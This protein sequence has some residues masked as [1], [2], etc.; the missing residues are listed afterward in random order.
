ML[1]E[2][3]SILHIKKNA[4]GKISELVWL[5]T[6]EAIS[7]TQTFASSISSDQN[8]DDEQFAPGDLF[9]T[10]VPDD[11]IEGTL[12]ALITEFNSMTNNTV[13]QISRS[14]FQIHYSEKSPGSLSEYCRAFDFEWATVGAGADVKGNVIVMALVPNGPT[15]Q[16]SRNDLHVRITDASTQLASATASSLT[17]VV[18]GNH[19]AVMAK[20]VTL[21]FV[22][23]L[24][25][26]V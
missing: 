25:G 21:S 18:V 16:R 11:I 26:V 13:K 19:Y 3:G 23:S 24:L 5:S 4:Q 7:F 12:V 17:N 20:G 2:S 8:T 22:K 1:P 10:G 6:A 14:K 9:P 15:L